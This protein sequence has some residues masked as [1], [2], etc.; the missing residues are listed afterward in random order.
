[1]NDAGILHIEGVVKEFEQIV[2]VRDVSFDV[3]N[4]E[5]FGLL[6]PNGAGKTTLIRMILGILQ[7]DHGSISIQLNG[8]SENLRKNRVGY[9]PEERG[10]YEDRRVGETLIYLATLNGMEPDRARDRALFWLNR[11]DLEKWFGHRLKELSKG[12]Q[13]KVQFVSSV[14][15]EP[16]LVVLDEP[17]SGLDPPSQDFFRDVIRELAE[18]GMTV[19]LSSHQMNLVE[20]LCDRVF[21]IHDGSQVLY[22]DLN[23]I[24]L[25]RDEDVVWM[26]YRKKGNQS[27]DQLLQDNAQI[28]IDYLDDHNA[29][30]LL[31]KG[32]SPTNMLQELLNHVEIDE[33]TMT[34]PS[35]HRL[36]VEII[37]DANA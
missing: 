16:E 31:P 7:P 8:V 36:F 15:H 18:G 19:L 4:G 13:Q 12:M 9:L 26:K 1:M 11:F 29:E 22:G 2:A 20:S 24:K 37:E 21:L 6:G 5:I 30:F 25:E 35:L 33:I 23:Q 17:F 27:L 3:Q 14:I 10:L 32:V 34:K 28:R